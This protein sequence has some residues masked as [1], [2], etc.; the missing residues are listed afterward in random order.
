MTIPLL[1][2][3]LKT[4]FLSPSFHKRKELL[5]LPHTFWKVIGLVQEE[6]NSIWMLIGKLLALKLPVIRRKR[7]MDASDDQ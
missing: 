5:V 7:K 2:F 6:V 3:H 4:F 1:S